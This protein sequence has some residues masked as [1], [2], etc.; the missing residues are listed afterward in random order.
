MGLEFLT[1]LLIG[2]LFIYRR[3][4]EIILQARQANK[5]LLE[6]EA[7]AYKAELASLKYSHLESTYDDSIELA[8]AAA[9][10]Q[11][12][13]ELID[14]LKKEI[15]NRDEEMRKLVEVSIK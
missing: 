10:I 5:L 15:R 13:A 9:K 14:W 1:G 2:G 6:K 4:Y 3:Q 8:E 12:Q 7:S 11:Y